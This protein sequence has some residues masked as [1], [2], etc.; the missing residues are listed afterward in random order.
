M[1]KK[2]KVRV[3]FETIESFLK[4][5]KVIIVYPVPKEFQPVILANPVKPKGIPIELGGDL[6]CLRLGPRRKL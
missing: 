2:R 1:I 4:R 5:G 3:K 6:G